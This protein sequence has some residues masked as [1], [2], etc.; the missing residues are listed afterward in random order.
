MEIKTTLDNARICFWRLHYRASAISSPPFMK[1]WVDELVRDICSTEEDLEDTRRALVA[2][3]R[4]FDLAIHKKYFNDRM[5][6]LK[7]RIRSFRAKKVEFIYEV[8]LV[9]RE[10]RK[11]FMRPVC[12]DAKYDKD[13]CSVCLDKLSEKLRQ[14]SGCNNLFHDVCVMSWLENKNTCPLGR[15]P[16]RTKEELDFIKGG[17]LIADA[18]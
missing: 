9:E 2:L 5:N 3:A 8:D 16:V 15:A 11:K 14:C 7:D 4:C 18:L 12:N 6:N 17:E 1:P 13:N 10:A